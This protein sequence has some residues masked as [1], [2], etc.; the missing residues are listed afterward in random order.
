MTSL[1]NT[2]IEPLYV[3]YRSLLI[4]VAYRITGMR[5]EAEDIVQDLF[6]HLSTTDWNRKQVNNIRA[7]LIQSTVNRSLNVLESARIKRIDYPGVWLPE[8]HIEDKDSAKPLNYEALLTESADTSMMLKDDIS[9]AVMVMLDQLTPIERAIFVLRQSFDFPYRDIAV[10]LDRSESACRKILSR[11]LPK[12]QAAQS[13]QLISSEHKLAFTH[14]F[15]QATQTGNFSNLLELLKSDIRLY[16]DGGGKVKA[17]LRPI[18]DRRRV[19]SFFNGIARKGS[20]AGE[21]SIVWINSEIGLQLQREHVTV[22]IY[23]FRYD[24]HGQVDQIFMISNPDKI[25]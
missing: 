8:P 1:F 24:V 12:L 13:S 10:W 7:Y 22:A 18:W 6:I 3:E 17:A 9:Y 5:S 14:A 2:S 25:R 23:S 11:A 21:W 20:L 15:L 16:T 19:V 4:A